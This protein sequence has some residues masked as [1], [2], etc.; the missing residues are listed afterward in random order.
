MTASSSDPHP[1][2]TQTS[3]GNVFRAIQSRLPWLL[4]AKAAAQRLV[5]RI[6]RHPFEPDFE[7]LAHLKLDG[8]VILDI[9]ANRGQSIDA[10]RLYHPTAPLYAFEPNGFLAERLARRFAGDTG[11]TLNRFGL[12][13]RPM[14]AP[15][16]VPYDHGFMYDGLAS[17]DRDEAAG[18]INASTMAWF[19][20]ARLEVRETVCEVRTPDGLGLRPAFVKIDVQGFERHVLEGG[21][22]T[23]LATQPVILMENSPEAEAW[24]IA[25]GWVRCA[26]HKGQLVE[27][28]RGAVNNIFFHRDRRAALAHLVRAN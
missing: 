4:E 7:I 18:W 19:D 1:A 27:G 9:G 10:I 14:R 12:G 15:L 24:L 6:R 20:P 5:R 26:W 16:H 28:A 22:Q 17:F 2:V 11:L 25:E 21:R 13:D 3:V 8:G 23:L